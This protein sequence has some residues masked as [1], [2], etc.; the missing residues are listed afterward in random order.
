VALYTIDTS[1]FNME[2]HLFCGIMASHGFQ[3]KEF[4][5]RAQGT[6]LPP[7]FDSGLP[8]GEGLQSAAGDLTAL[9]LEPRGKTAGKSDRRLS[10][11]ASKAQLARLERMGA[12]M[13]HDPSMSQGLVRSYPFLLQ[14]GDEL[15]IKDVRELLAQYRTVVLK[16]EGLKAALLAG[17]ASPS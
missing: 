7:P 4:L 9:G 10:K 5:P 14:N 8:L 3:P 13:V 11:Q 1:H 15:F 12:H 6:K 16:Y 17:G 2:P